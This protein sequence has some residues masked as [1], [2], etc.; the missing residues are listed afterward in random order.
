MWSTSLVWSLPSVNTTPPNWGMLCYLATLLLICFKTLNPSYDITSMLSSFHLS[1]VVRDPTRITSH[2]SSLID[3]VYVSNLS[4]LHS[5]S[6]K[7]PL[8]SS[9]HCSI[10]TRGQSHTSR[11]SAE[12]SGGTP[13]LTGMLPM[14][15]WTQ[16]SFQWQ[17]TLTLHGHCGEHFLSTL[18][19]FIPSKTIVICKT[20]PWLTPSIIK[21][22]R[23][24][25][26]IHSKAKTL[27]TPATWNK[28][29]VIRKS[30]VSAIR[31]D[32]S[33][34]FKSLRSRIRSSK[35]FWSVFHSL[36]PSK[37]RIPH[38]LSDD[39]LLFSEESQHAE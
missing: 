15:P 38:L 5:C 32:K 35:D 26:L 24:C 31:R 20:L 8:G 2:S 22:F 16:F 25:S 12:L 34:F 13:W 36:S 7:P 27:N 19:K 3:H 28:F 29:F 1:K 6:T 30:V 33:D 39:S 9:D 14:T 21:L 18:P 37:Q 10:L 23:K 11:G 17:M 4:S